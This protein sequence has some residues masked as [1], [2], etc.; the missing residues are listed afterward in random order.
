MMELRFTPSFER[1]YTKITHGNDVLHKKV[2]KQLELLRQNVHHPSLR[3]HKI[4][5]SSFW[6]ISI[7]K[8]IRVLVILEKQWIYIYHIGK[9]EEVY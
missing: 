7:D 1:E 8:S 4:G 5:S 2:K 6:S 3:L 9:L